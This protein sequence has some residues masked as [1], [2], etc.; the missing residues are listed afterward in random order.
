M[1]MSIAGGAGGQVDGAAGVLLRLHHPLAGGQQRG[2]HARPALL[3]DPLCGRL[4]QVN[5]LHPGSLSGNVYLQW[6]C[7][8][9]R[10]ATR[11]THEASYKGG[12]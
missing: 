8:L 7:T 12:I 10:R 9:I 1:T 4:L 2:L 5:L 11:F 6:H 3:P